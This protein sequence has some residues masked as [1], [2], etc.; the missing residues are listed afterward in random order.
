MSQPL[1][2]S[3]ELNTPLSYSAT[4]VIIISSAKYRFNEAQEGW[5]QE[6][7]RGQST[8]ICMPLRAGNCLLP[9]KGIH[10]RVKDI[11]LITANIS[12]FR[13]IID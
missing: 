2:S 1:L 6:P 13:R 12:F 4:V 11:A 7:V 10:N 8:S 9:V 5:H 3:K